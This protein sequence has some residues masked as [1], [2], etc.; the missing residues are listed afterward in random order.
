VRILSSVRFPLHD[1]LRYRRGWSATQVLI[2]FVIMQVLVS[3]FIL[4]VFFK[5]R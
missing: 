2:K 1:H 5:V 4:G 3:F